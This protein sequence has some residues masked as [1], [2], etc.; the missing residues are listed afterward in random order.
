MPFPDRC[1]LVHFYISYY[2]VFTTSTPA[3]VY[4]IDVCILIKLFLVIVTGQELDLAIPEVFD[5]SMYIF[6]PDS[7]LEI[8]SDD[9]DDDENDDDDD[10]K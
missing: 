2:N 7:D 10:D 1:L 5:T 6:D 3:K 4:S 9:D 8:P